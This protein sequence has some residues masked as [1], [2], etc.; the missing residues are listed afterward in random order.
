MS[1]QTI[2]NTNARPTP[3]PTPVQEPA[4]PTPKGALALIRPH[5]WIK[6]FFVFIPMFFGGS[7]LNIEDI[8][9]S[10]ITFFAFSFAASSIYCFNDIYD[11]E[12]DRRHPVKCRRPI[13]SGA[14]SIRS[15]YLLMGLDRK[16]TRLN[17]SHANISYAVFCLKKKTTGLISSFLI[18]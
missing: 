10:V 11:V 17:S 3:G 13:A 7:L 4:K 8:W 9:S 2:D 12:A 5:Q 15:A 1:N 16:S 6:N 14:V 18:L